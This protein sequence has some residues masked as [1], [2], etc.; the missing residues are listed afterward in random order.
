MIRAVRA[1]RG[2]VI[3]VVVVV[4]AVV[5]GVV[6]GHA[7]GAAAPAAR[8]GRRGTGG[9]PDAERH[10]RGVRVVRYRL[11]DGDG[12]VLWHVDVLRVR[13]LDDDR[14]PLGLDHLLGVRLEIARGLRL[15][16]Y[17]LDGGHD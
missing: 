4:V 9:E 5:V 11:E 1:R 3:R 6:D 16:P 17:L 15:L 7:P 2:R 10:D 8:R 14:A 12:V 13:R